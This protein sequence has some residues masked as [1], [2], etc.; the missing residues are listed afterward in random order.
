MA[1]KAVS[2]FAIS[3]R[4]AAYNIVKVSE[5]YEL[6]Q[7]VLVAVHPQYETLAFFLSTYTTSK[8]LAGITSGLSGA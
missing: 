3:I 2:L 5:G 4:L 6:Y 8:D 7:P 1:S